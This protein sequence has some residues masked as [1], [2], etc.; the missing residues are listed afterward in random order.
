M[1]TQKKETSSQKPKISYLTL[2]SVVAAMSVIAIHTNGCFWDFS[3][4]HYW[5]TANIL[6]CVFYFAVDVFFMITGSTLLDFFDKYTLRE[7]FSKRIKKTVI[8][9]VA[10]TLIGILYRVVIAKNLL[11]A[12][13]TP[14]FV[15]DGL[16]K[17]NIVNL[18]WFFGPLFCVYLSIPLFAAVP[19]EKRNLV[20]SYVAVASLVFNVL[21]PFINGV[22][23]INIACPLSVTVGSSYLLYICVGYLLS[24]NEINV[25]IRIFSYILAVAGLLLQI[26]GTYKLSIAAGQINGLYKGY[27]NIPCFFYAVGIFI[28][29]RY[30]SAY[31]KNE[32]FWK[33][34]NFIGR[35]TFPMYLMQWFFID[36]VGRFTH[37]N[38]YSMYYRL[39][40]PIPIAAAIILITMGLRKIP[41]LRYIVP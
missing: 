31:V 4:N 36:A 14:R 18:Y 5:F 16:T 40:A 30:F 39:G 1:S 27:V 38:T 17:F 33:I 29:I 7:Y 13:V 9:F 28:A 23:E 8:P 26:I 10:W 12:D 20:Y 2:A 25:N 37:I 32:T 34:I 22:F 3:T 15:F 6:E 41:V 11:W 19:K 24:H 21:I 35:Y